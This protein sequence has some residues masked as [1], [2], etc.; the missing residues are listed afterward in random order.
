VI[1]AALER[2]LAEMLSDVWEEF[3]RA[4][5]RPYPQGD[6]TFA[7]RAADAYALTTPF[8]DSCAEDNARAT[9]ADYAAGVLREL[10]DGYALVSFQWTPELLAELQVDSSQLPM[11][12][13]RALEGALHRNG[14]DVWLA[15]QGFPISLPERED[16]E[17]SSSPAIPSE[18]G[19]AGVADLLAGFTAAVAGYRRLG[20]LRQSLGGNR[21][22]LDTRASLREAACTNLVLAR[23]WLTYARVQM[24]PP[25]QAISGAWRLMVEVLFEF[26][27]ATTTEDVASLH[28]PAPEAITAMLR[29]AGSPEWLRAHGA[30]D[31]EWTL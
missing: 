4:A 19:E 14:V 7:R 15:T 3:W 12:E 18:A 17:S 5:A 30:A 24:G 27:C 6:E 13:R 21:A 1:S 9:P 16:D 2:E 20:A 10:A 11:P 31:S 23:R 8:V 22:I 25:A 28:V 26:S 29:G